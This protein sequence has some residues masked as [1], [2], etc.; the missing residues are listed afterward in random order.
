MSSVQNSKLV[1]SYLYARPPGDID[2]VS[3]AR[4]ALVNAGIGEGIAIFDNDPNILFAKDQNSNVQRFKLNTFLDTQYMS[5]RMDVSQ[6]RSM[7]LDGGSMQS[8][9]DLFNTFHI[10][11]LR[12][13]GLP[14]AYPV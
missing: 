11:A 9:I 14:R 2:L 1:D 8:W 10:P 4:V 6:E 12:A 5:L 3:A 7:L 13:Y